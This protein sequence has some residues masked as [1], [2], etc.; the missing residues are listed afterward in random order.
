VIQ[1]IPTIS[2]EVRRLKKKL[3]GDRHSYYPLIH[4][5]ASQAFGFAPIGVSSLGIDLMSFNSGKVYGPKGVGALFVKRGVALNSIF[6]S[7]GQE[8]GLRPGTEPVALIASFARALEIS[9]GS[10][11]K[12][13]LRIANLREYFLEKLEKIIKESCFKDLDLDY[14]V[15][16]SQNYNSPHII[17]LSF[18]GLESDQMVIEL[19]A[20]GIS[21]SSKSACKTLDPQVSHVLSAIGYDDNSWGAIR[22]S[23]GRDTQNEDIDFAIVALQEVLFKLLHTKKE[24]LL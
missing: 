13:S 11:S 19:D 4:T 12:E 23:F 7:G 9:E 2:K 5:D 10:K 14:K 15:N 18:K 16:G 21:V 1:D 17:S 6:Y 8:S 24:F 22:F 20:K 3:H